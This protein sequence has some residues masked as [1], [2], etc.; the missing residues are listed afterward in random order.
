MMPGPTYNDD[1][2]YVRHQGIVDER[3]LA[4]C[5]MVNGKKMWISKSMIRDV[6]AEYVVVP[7]WVADSKKCASDF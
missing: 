2:A 4:R 6:N 1:N 3:P 7:K 5:F